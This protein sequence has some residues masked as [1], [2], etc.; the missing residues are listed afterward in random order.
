MKKLYKARLRVLSSLTSDERTTWSLFPDNQLYLSKKVFRAAN[1]R[2]ERDHEMGPPG[3]YES[4][5]FSTGF[6]NDI[7]YPFSCY[8]YICFND[9]LDKNIV[10]K[11]ITAVQLHGVTHTLIFIAWLE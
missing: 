4:L 9:S 8:M 10:C 2:Q 6:L 3:G 11:H 5:A 7:A 1:Y